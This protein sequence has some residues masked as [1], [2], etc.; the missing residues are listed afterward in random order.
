MTIYCSDSVLNYLTLDGFPSNLCDYYLLNY[1]FADI[2]LNINCSE[3]DFP[4]LHLY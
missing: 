4:V 1:Y 2:I 3:E